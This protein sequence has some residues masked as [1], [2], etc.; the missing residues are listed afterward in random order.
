MTCYIILRSSHSIFKQKIIFSF[1]ENELL[2]IRGKDS[3]QSKSTALT[4][5]SDPQGASKAKRYTCRDN[6]KVFP[7][8]E[9]CPNLEKSI[10][11]SFKPKNY[12]KDNGSKM[13]KRKSTDVTK[14]FKYVIGGRQQLT[15]RNRYTLNTHSKVNSSQHSKRKGVEPVGSSNF[16]SQLRQHKCRHMNKKVPQRINATTKGEPS[17]LERNE[18]ALF[19]EFKESKVDLNQKKS[20]FNIENKENMFVCIISFLLTLFTV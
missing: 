1:V 5:E 7:N 17:D 16:W 18:L 6:R 13:M 4:R 20:Y 2:P 9:V 14:Q 19:S 15:D 12:M 11:K 10:I 8:L 3:L